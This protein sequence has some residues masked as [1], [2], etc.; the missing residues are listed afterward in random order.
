MWPFEINLLSHDQIFIMLL[1]QQTDTAEQQGKR[2]I[3][4]Q[5]SML[6]LSLVKKLAKGKSAGRNEKMVMLSIAVFITLTL[7]TAAEAQH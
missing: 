2:I 5:Q 1:Q 4:C 6:F 3:S 7:F